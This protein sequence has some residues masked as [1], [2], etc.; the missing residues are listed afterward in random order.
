[1]KMRF[2]FCLLLF[3][4]GVFYLW[5]ET[6]ITEISE[7]MPL[8]ATER[9]LASVAVKSRPFSV[10]KKDDLVQSGLSQEKIQAI[11]SLRDFHNSQPVF[12]QENISKR[13]SM[14][15]ELAKSP[16][17]TVEAFGRIMRESRDDGLKSFLLNLVMHTD[18]LEEEKAEIFLAR[19]Q[20][21][22]HFSQNGIVPDEE[23]SIIIGLSHLSRLEDEQ[24]KYEAMEKLKSQEELVKNSGFQKAFQD[25]FG[26]PI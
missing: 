21:G 4:A 2:F 26:Q 23:L 24:V 22:A 13:I 17:E 8:P 20:A 7:D 9:K 15:D 10:V 18:L 6:E 25:Y 1:M 11:Y 5:G 12:N 16:H 19:I 14:L 3:G